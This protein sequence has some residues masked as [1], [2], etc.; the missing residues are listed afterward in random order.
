MEFTSRRDA[1]R[2]TRRD[3]SRDTR[4]HASRDTRRD[5]SRD[6][7]RDASQR[8]HDRGEVFNGG[9]EEGDEVEAWGGHGVGMGWAWGGHGDEV[10]AWAR[11]MGCPGT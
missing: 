5:A 10:E 8:R 11:F 4:R 1:S 7:R 6:T 3:A 2:D 9:V